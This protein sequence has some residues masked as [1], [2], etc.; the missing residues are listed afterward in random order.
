MLGGQTPYVGVLRDI[1]ERKQQE[2]ALARIRSELQQA[3]ERLLEQ[4]R[5]DALTGI[6]NRRHFSDTLDR[7]IRRAGRATDA[8]LSLILCDIDHFKLYNDTYGHIAGDKCLQEV[9]AV[10]RSTFKRGG[11]LVARYGGEEFAVIMPMTS[12]DNAVLVAERL[13][14]ALWQRALPH[15]ASRTTDRVTLSIGVAT[16]ASG[17]T[18]AA[19][20][21]ASMADEALYMAKA[22]GRNRVEQYDKDSAQLPHI[23]TG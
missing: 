11:D 19:R 4:T 6:A 2:A 21:L 16:M 18:I 1:S 12:A 23:S 20:K 5:T 13:R 9:A 3:N 15:T 8:P 14:H 17:E 7:E 10:I 22:S